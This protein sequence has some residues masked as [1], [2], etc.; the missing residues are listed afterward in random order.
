MTC[1]HRPKLSLSQ[2]PTLQLLRAPL[3]YLLSTRPRQLQQQPISSLRPARSIKCTQPQPIPG[4]P[5]V[6]SSTPQRQSLFHP[7][8]IGRQPPRRHIRNHHPLHIL[9][10]I[11]QQH[12]STDHLSR[13]KI[14]TSTKNYDTRILSC[15][16]PSRLPLLN[17]STAKW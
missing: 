7:I 2:V 4:Q 13:N 16:T 9:P 11:T 10:L 6:I 1:R 14:N 17:A 15:W 8:P 12:Q 3:P 5:Q